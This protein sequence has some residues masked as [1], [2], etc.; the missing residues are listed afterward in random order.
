[1]SSV[2]ALSPRTAE[3]RGAG[4]DGVTVTTRAASRGITTVVPR[5]VEPHDLPGLEPFD[6]SYESIV[7]DIDNPRF[8]L[9]GQAVIDPELR[10]VTTDAESEEAVLRS[11]REVPRRCTHVRGTVAYLSNFWIDNYYHWMQLTLPLLRLYSEIE[12]LD[13]I[14]QFYVGPSSLRGVQTETLAALGIAPERVRRDPCSADRLLAAFLIHREQHRGGLEYR[15]SLGCAYVRN[16]FPVSDHGRSD[17]RRLYVSRGRVP[18]RRLLNEEALIGLLSSY[19]FTPVSMDGLSVGQQGALFAGAEVVV[20]VHGAALTNLLF[21]TFGS[22]V[23]EIFPPEFLEVSH[24]AT[25][26]H[27]RLDYYYVLGD[28]VARSNQDFVVDL[29]KLDELLHRFALV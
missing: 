27:S 21:S 15:D 3:L 17:A 28:G 10:I 4:W 24:F 2:A 18:N 11:R 13:R 20:A 26:T 14:D 6:D 1:V 5:H 29:S 22:A 9:R 7:L 12:P 16:A 19:G 8:T 25:A 23:V